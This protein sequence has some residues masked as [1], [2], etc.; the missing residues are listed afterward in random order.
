MKVVGY[1]I[2]P[3]CGG[4]GRG[5]YIIPNDPYGSHFQQYPCEM[6]QGRGK[7]PSRKGMNKLL[8]HIEVN[9]PDFY[10]VLEIDHGEN[11]IYVSD[12]QNHKHYIIKVETLE[13]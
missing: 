1:A 4:T 2:C 9:L 12:Q 13:E 6:C 11:A 3:K 8:S 10:A 5:E 7:I